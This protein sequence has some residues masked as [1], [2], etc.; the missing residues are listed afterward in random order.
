M[1]ARR[2][3]F[4]K[5][6]AGSRG[7]REACN[8]GAQRNRPAV[9]L[10]AGFAM[11][12]ARLDDPNPPLLR[13]RNDTQKLRAAKKSPSFCP[14]LSLIM[15]FASRITFWRDDGSRL[16]SA[17]EG[18]MPGTGS[19]IDRDVAFRFVGS[20]YFEPAVRRHGAAFVDCSLAIPPGNADFPIYASRQNYRM[21]RRHRMRSCQ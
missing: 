10:N 13:H 9:R 17:P 8:A 5:S 12:W 15:T 11:R 3:N 19:A 7:A 6:G 21:R 18:G 14:G 2:R 1:D 20:P 4:D 16:L